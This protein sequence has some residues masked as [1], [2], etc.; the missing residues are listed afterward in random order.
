MVEGSAAPGPLPA[1]ES[2]E[3]GGDSEESA[4]EEVTEG[5]TEE[6]EWVL[7]GNVGM[8]ELFDGEDNE[9]LEKCV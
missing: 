5:E 7:V 9:V 4:Q 3:A 8:D 2:A 6:E 1:A